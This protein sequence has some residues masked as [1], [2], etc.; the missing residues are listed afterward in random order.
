[1]RESL[2]TDFLKFALNKLYRRPVS[3]HFGYAL[4]EFSGIVSKRNDGIRV[5]LPGMCN[6]SGKRFLSRGI[7]NLCV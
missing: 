3:K 2:K 6:H 1:M 7:T 5:H 4:S